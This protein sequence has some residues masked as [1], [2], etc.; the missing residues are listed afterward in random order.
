M[1]RFICLLMCAIAAA[2][3]ALLVAPAND[4]QAASPPCNVRMLDIGGG[5]YLAEC[6]GNCDGGLPPATWVCAR[7][8]LITPTA[9]LHFCLCDDDVTYDVNGDPWVGD[10]GEEDQDPNAWAHPDQ[11][12]RGIVSIF[13]PTYNLICKVKNCE[14]SCSQVTDGDTTQ[15]T[16]DD[17]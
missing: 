6:Y 3:S 1:R 4:A 14:T 17:E 13:A 8:L 7:R 12:C 5:R 2:L 11:E 16:C 15:C 10:P 9:Y